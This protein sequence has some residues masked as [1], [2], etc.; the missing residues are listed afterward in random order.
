MINNKTFTIVFFVLIVALLVFRVRISHLQ[1]KLS[2]CES[3]NINLSQSLDFQNEAIKK[4]KLE[5]KNYPEKA[6]KK[7]REII[8]QIQAIPAPANKDGTTCEEAL[9]YIIKL[10]S[11]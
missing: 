5:M 1:D 4:M 7:E 9:D 6:Q 8:S 10:E 3:K 2:L 11:L